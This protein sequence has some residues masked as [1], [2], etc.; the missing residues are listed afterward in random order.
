VITRGDWES[1]L[2]RIPADK[3]RDVREQP[4]A[5]ES[6]SSITCWVSKTLAARARSEGLDRDP[7]VAAKLAVETDRLL[8]AQMTRRSKATRGA[9]FDRDPERNTAPAPASCISSAAA[10]NIRR[11]KRSTCRTS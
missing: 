4:A 5:R 10:R 7:R 6:R 9:E 2:E 11:P 3:A 1:D 8:A